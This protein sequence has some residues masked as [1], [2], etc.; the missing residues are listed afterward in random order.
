MLADRKQRKFLETVELQIGMR[1]YDPDKR[2]NGNVRLPNQVYNKVR[3]FIIWSRFVYSPMPHT[4]KK[5]L[6]ML[7][8]SLTSTVSRPSIRIRT[9]SKSGPRSTTSSSL[10]TQSESKSPNFWA[11]SW[12]RW[13]NSPWTWLKERRSSARLTNSS[14]PSNSRARKLTAWALLLAPSRFPKKV[15]GRTSP[16]PSTSWSPLWRR[17]GKT[18]E[19]F[20]SRPPW[21]RATRSSADSPLFKSLLLH[22]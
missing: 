15:S 5:P 11:T 9:K 12:S 22:I 17:A 20:T 10:P 21:A 19:P 2:F 4:S 7:S 6:P 8:L 13:A 3:V 16:W 18:L 1:D 14:K